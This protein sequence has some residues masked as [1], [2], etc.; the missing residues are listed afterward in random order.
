LPWT[1]ATLADF[2]AANLTSFSSITIA[3]VTEYFTIPGQ[4]AIT[5]PAQAAGNNCTLKAFH[6]AT[7]NMLFGYESAVTA[8]EAQ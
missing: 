8:F 7:G 5:I 3:S 6:A 2:T 1:G 4:Y